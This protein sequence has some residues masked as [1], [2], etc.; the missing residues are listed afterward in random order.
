MHEVEFKPA[1]FLLC[2]QQEVNLTFERNELKRFIDVLYLIFHLIVN[3]KQ[4]V[5]LVLGKLP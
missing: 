4:K 3:K 2:Y 1:A 5:W